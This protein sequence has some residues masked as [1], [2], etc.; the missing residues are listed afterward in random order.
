LFG[1][2]FLKTLLSPKN[3]M[4]NS[5]AELLIQS[6][7]QNNKDITPCANEIMDSVVE[8]P[9]FVSLNPTTC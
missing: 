4:R 6:T 9:N 8:I 2:F 3:R 1:L 5:G 7:Q